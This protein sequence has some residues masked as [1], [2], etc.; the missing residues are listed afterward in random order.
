MHHF[1]LE[2]HRACQIGSVSCRLAMLRSSALAVLAD[3][4]ASLINLSMP[5]LFLAAPEQV[6]SRQIRPRT[7]IC[8]PQLMA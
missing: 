7:Y 6:H 3:V 4:D 8:G 2:V 5:A 1:A